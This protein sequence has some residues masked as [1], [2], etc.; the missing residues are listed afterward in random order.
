MSSIKASKTRLDRLS[1]GDILRDVEH[2]EYVAEREGVVEVSRIIFPFAIVLTQD[3][4]LEHDHV[5]R[6]SEAPSGPQD[7]W[8]LSVLLAPMYNAAHVFAGEHLSG[9]NMYMQTIPS[10]PK[11]VLKNNETPRYH[12]MEFTEDVPMPPVVVDFKHYFS[13]NLEYLKRLSVSKFVCQVPTL[14]RED[15]SDRFAAYLS[16]IALPFEAIADKAALPTE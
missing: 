16:R 13:V 9:L 8:L 10:R 12:Y 15:I 6:Q 2:V 14:F 7:K 5:F 1:Q 4:D 11:H 3:C